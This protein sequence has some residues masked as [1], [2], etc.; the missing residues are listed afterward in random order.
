[1]LQGQFETSLSTHGILMTDSMVR[2]LEE[3]RAQLVS[4]I[5]RIQE[6]ALALGKA[7]GAPRA[8][9]RL[10]AR[11]RNLP[12][13]A[14]FRPFATQEA[15]ATALRWFEHPLV[16]GLLQ[17]G[18]HARAVLSARPN[19]TQADIDELVA[20]RTGRQA[21]LT[22]EEPPPLLLLLRVLPGEGVLHRLVAPPSVLHDQLFHLNEASRLPTVTVNVV[23]YAAGGHSGLP[24]AFVIAELGGSPRIVFT[25]DV[26]G[27]RVTEV[28]SVVSEVGLRP[29]SPS[30]GTRKLG[31][32]AGR[33]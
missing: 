4:S 8:F 5:A 25:D 1:M 7:F 2:S 18:E 3:Y 10:E 11:L 33:H 14:S 19:S 6:L 26:S 21:V 15:E 31:H 16:P 30:S 12:F 32:A 24:G 17:A 23:P 13:P 9:E 27:G 29:I 22:R 28:P 20:G